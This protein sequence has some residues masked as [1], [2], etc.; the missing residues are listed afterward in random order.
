MQRV[1]RHSPASDN[2]TWRSPARS[3]Q[4]SRSGCQATWTGAEP[5]R[6]SAGRCAQQGL[7]ALI[8]RRLTQYWRN[9]CCRMLSLHEWLPCSSCAD[10][11]VSNPA[12]RHVHRCPAERTAKVNPVSAVL[13]GRC[14]ALSRSMP[15]PCSQAQCSVC[16]YITAACPSPS[17]VARR[18]P[19]EVVDRAPPGARAAALQIPGRPHPQPR[20]GCSKPDGKVG[21]MWRWPC[22]SFLTGRGGQGQQAMPPCFKSPA[23]GTRTARGVLP[24]CLPVPWAV[25]WRCA[26]QPARCHDNA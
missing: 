6:S 19:T 21:I 11:F 9:R 23:S 4:H 16:P 15:P 5:K 17:C 7:L 26:Q 10:C 14:R 18:G 8:M 13:G 20:G 1:L 22:A 2:D 3:H 25:G 12:L 24:S